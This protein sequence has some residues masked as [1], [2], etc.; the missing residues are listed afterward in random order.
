MP[1]TAEQPLSLEFSATDTNVRETMRHVMARIGA[2]GVAMEDA[3]R[4]EIALAEALN[5][6]VEHGFAGLDPGIVR[7]DLQS[8]PT[9]I[10]VEIADGGHP[11]PN[12]RLPEPKRHDLTCEL[13]DLPEGGFGW[14]LIHDLVSKI[15]YNR[16][17]GENHLCMIFDLTV[18]EQARAEE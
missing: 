17:A 11:Y 1:N 7:L 3:N 8:V 12:N 4:L 14:T 10:R 6:V 2:A 9:S 5:N 18:A 16:R 15:E 13:A